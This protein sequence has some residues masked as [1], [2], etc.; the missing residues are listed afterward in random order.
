M[1]KRNRSTIFIAIFFVFALAA[2]SSCKRN[3]EKQA[4]EMLENQMENATGQNTEVDIQKDKVVIESDTMNAIIETGAKVWP[5]K[6]PAS[7]PR[8]QGGSI[9]AT[10]Y[11]ETGG[12]KTWG[13]HFEGIKPEALSNYGDALKKAGFKVMKISMGK[14]GNVTG[15]K[16]NLI[17]TAMFG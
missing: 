8:F 3:A 12:I 5:D 13:I 7:V 10:T 9:K 4:E 1:N 15:E 17:V 6:A 14:G 16:E 11:S 2:I